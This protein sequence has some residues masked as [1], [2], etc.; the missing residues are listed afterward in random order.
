MSPLAQCRLAVEGGYKRVRL[1]PTVLATMYNRA[2]IGF[3]LFSVL[4]KGVHTYIAWMLL[5]GVLTVEYTTAGKVEITSTHV[6][7]DKMADIL[8]D[9]NFGCFLNENE[10]IPIQISLKRV[11]RSPID[12]KA[13]SVQAMVWRRTGDKALPEIML[14]QFPDA[15]MWYLRER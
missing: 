11:P 5:F 12:N 3:E 14:T 4:L 9:G 7:L 10:R 6:T 1:L 13:A 15:Y 8:T 2:T